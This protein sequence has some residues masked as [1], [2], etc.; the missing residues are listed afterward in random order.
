MVEALKPWP[1]LPPPRPEYDWYDCIEDPIRP[2]IRL[3]RDNGF[4]TTSSCGHEMWFACL[5]GD[6]QELWQLHQFLFRCGYQGFEVS[7]P[8]WKQRPYALVRVGLKRE[9][10]P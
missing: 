1:V 5:V 4:N 3:L 7:R 6:D 10:A 8:D 2:L 9:V